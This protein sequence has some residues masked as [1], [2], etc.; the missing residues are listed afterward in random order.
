VSFQHFFIIDF[1]RIITWVISSQPL[2]QADLPA[3]K[4][5]LLKDDKVVRH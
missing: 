3:A 1:Q 4:A 5:G 2:P